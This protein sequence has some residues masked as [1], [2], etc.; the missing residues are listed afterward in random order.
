MIS[1]LIYIIAF[2]FANLLVQY[3]GNIGLIFSSLFLVPFDFIMRCFFHEKFKGKKLVFKLGLLVLLS[4]IITY[5]INFN[6]FN[7]A[8]ASCIGFLF[9]QVFASLF[10]QIFI[11]KSYFIKV[12]GS[13]AI[14]IIIDSFIFQLIAFN[15]INIII[16]FSQFVLKL[17]GGFFWYW[18]IF[19]KLKL[20]EKW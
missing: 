14:A 15:E 20:Q 4:S 1:Y 18:I 3:F 2:V 16:T 11:N 19:K 9:A 12:N 7:I 10:Y 6:T 17:F 5:I 8:L 13:D